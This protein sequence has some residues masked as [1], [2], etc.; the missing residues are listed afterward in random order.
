V[1]SQIEIGNTGE[2]LIANIV[3]NVVVRLNNLYQDFDQTD[4]VIVDFFNALK[5]ENKKEIKKKLLRVLKESQ[6]LRTMIGADK[7]DALY[8]WMLKYDQAYNNSRPVD[9]DKYAEF[10]QSKDLL[11]QLVSCVKDQNPAV[12]VMTTSDGNSISYSFDRGQ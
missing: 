3:E 5:T 6:N 10:E 11:M 8:N 9:A 12:Y 7:L 1:V 2:T 4:K